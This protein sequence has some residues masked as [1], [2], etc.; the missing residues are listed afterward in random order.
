MTGLKDMLTTALVQSKRYRV[1]ERSQLQEVQAEQKLGA[2]G[3]HRGRDRAYRG[4]GHPDR[5]GG[6]RLGSEHRR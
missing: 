6:D 5:G 3:G 1:L 2:S 4:R